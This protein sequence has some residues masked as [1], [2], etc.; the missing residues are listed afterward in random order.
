[1]ASVRYAAFTLC[2]LGG[3]VLG[4]D[5]ETSPQEPTEDPC[6][7]LFGQPSENTG[8][9]PEACRAECACAEPPWQAQ[10]FDDGEL[11]AFESSVL[12]DSPPQ[13][14]EDPY[15]NPSLYP[16]QPDKICGLV[17]DAQ[18][19]GSY[20]VE[21]FD[22]EQQLQQAGGV[23]THHGACGRC[24]SLQDL[25]V[26]IRNTDLTGP[27]RACGIEGMSQGQDRN[28]E[29]LQEIGFSLLCA[30]A[31]YYNTLNTRTVCLEQCL[32]ALNE[33]H[34]LPDGSLNPC[35]QCDEDNSGAVFKAVSGRTRRNSGL[36]SAL[37]RPCSTV[38]RVTHDYPL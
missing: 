15:D 33:P 30:E 22:D 16:H 19:A 3:V 24:S 35:I 9:G 25:A 13:L 8:L 37:C 5:D 17:P 14:T 18:A 11:V 6:Q 4:C 29:C 23:L 21:T 36:A 27:V 38:K 1:M 28:I 12:L 2:L 20:R 34:H 31:W 7:V 10:T 32:V 26:Y